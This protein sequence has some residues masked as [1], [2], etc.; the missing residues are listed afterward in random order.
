MSPEPK[1]GATLMSIPAILVEI[2]VPRRQPSSTRMQLPQAAVL[3]RTQEG[4][5][6]GVVDDRYQER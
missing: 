4:L 6:V 2:L 3:Q 5:P 1:L